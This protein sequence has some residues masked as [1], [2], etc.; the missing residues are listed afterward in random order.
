MRH[1]SRAYARSKP[2]STG[3]HTHAAT[4]AR[5]HA[6]VAHQRRD[7]LHTLTTRL[8]T[9]HDVVVVEDLHT[10]GMVRNRRLARA[11]A[12]TGMGEIRR[13]LAYKTLWYGSRLVVA[14]RWYPSSKTCSGCG[15]QNPHLRLSD[16]TFTCQSCALVMDR[17]TNAA[18]NLKNLV[19]ASTSETENARGADRRT[20]PGGQVATKRE[21]G[22]RISGPGRGCPAER[23]G[24]MTRYLASPC[25]GSS[26]SLTAA[27]AY[28][29]AARTSARSR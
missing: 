16:R 10:A 15:W 14:D 9:N 13:Q 24:G 29:R 26:R 22:T 12:D 7:G 23:R 11:V 17:D 18:V 2:G 8:A 27:A 1:Q 3:R 5:I 4:L 19:A 28:S 25:N 20:H 21:P 6:H